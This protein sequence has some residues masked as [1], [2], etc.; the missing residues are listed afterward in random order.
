MNIHH[1]IDS[2]NSSDL[3]LRFRINDGFE[4]FTGNVSCG[5]VHELF[6]LNPVKCTLKLATENS[7]KK[8]EIDLKCD[9]TKLYSRGYVSFFKNITRREIEYLNSWRE[10]ET[11]LIDWFISGFA[12]LNSNILNGYRIPNLVLAIDNFISNYPI[13]M[14]QGDFIAN[15]VVPMD[16]GRKI[17]EEFSVEAPNLASL[18]ANAT[19]GIKKLIPNIVLLQEHLKR[20]LDRFR[21]SQYVSDLSASMSE[22]RTP[23]DSVIHQQTGRPR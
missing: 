22:I 23:L 6:L 21:S 14:G 18:S 2:A 4:V 16:L 12:V 3:V 8:I 10:G 15:L 17:I 1:R 11:I 13:R 19:P 9:E 5:A 7:N 20:A